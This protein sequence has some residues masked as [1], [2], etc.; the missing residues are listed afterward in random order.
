MICAQRTI[1][2]LVR[3]E[4]LLKGKMY[5]LTGTGLF[6]KTPR[7]RQLGDKTPIPV[8]KQDKISDHLP[9]TTQIQLP[10]PGKLRGK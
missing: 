10:L 3:E 4:V 9:K 7:S 8:R 2:L 6:G 5:K 1:V